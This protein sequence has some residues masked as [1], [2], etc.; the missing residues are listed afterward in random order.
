MVLQKNNNNSGPAS[1]ANSKLVTKVRR[2]KTA[3]RAA[4]FKPAETNLLLDMVEEWLPAG[5]HMWQTVMIN[6]N[7]LLMDVGEAE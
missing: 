2:V 1:S 7:R 3:T 6:Y 4:K 5:P